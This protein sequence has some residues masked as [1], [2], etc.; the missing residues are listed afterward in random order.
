M[1]N[2]FGKNDQPLYI[3]IKNNIL[4]KI[5][6]GEFR[7]NKLPPMRDIAEDYKVSVNTILRAYNELQKEGYATSTV[8]RGTFI[9]SDPK[10]MKDHNR[11]TFLC[12][13]AKR[14]LEEAVSNGFSMEE[15]ERALKDYIAKQK[16]IF[17]KV[18][19]AFIECNI[20]Q[21]HYFSN[22][23]ELDPS[24]HT[25][26]ILLSELKS[27]PKASYKKL[28]DCDFIITSFHHLNEV[29]NFSS[30]LNKKIVGI[31]LDP[32]IRTIVE[33]AKIPSDS[34]IGIVTISE[35]FKQIIRKIIGDLNLNFREYLDTHT[36]D[37]EEIR[38]LV[39]K[40]DAVLVSP[41][42]KS[43]VEKYVLPGVKIIELIFTPDRTSIN[44][45]KIALLEIHN[46]SQQEKL[47]DLNQTC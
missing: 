42:Q 9:I 40:C 35:R 8:G 39:T 15:F 38:S 46:G 10:A 21:L 16:E 31:S 37:E 11:E 23:L 25:I 17:S 19:V 24:I 44:N 12:N 36:Q 47:P 32:E 4:E 5:Q 6:N 18:H 22:H 43:V 28:Q 3:R 14:T 27:R 7:E 29:H 45:I 30:K 41:H 33:L 20:E 34:R 2:T 13:L 26:P 1:K